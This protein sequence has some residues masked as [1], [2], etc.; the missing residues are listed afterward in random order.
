MEEKI[1]LNYYYG[2]EP[3]RLC[4]YRIPKILF[5]KAYFAGLSTDAKV[6]YGLMHDLMSMSIENRWLDSSNRVYIYFSV[7]RACAYLGCGKDKALKLFAELDT[8]TGIGLIER[9]KR[10][11][12]KAD[13]IY[14]K[15]FELPSDAEDKE[16]IKKLKKNNEAN[17]SYNIVVEKTDR[18]DNTTAIFEKKVVGKTEWSENPTPCGRENRLLEVGKS[19]SNKNNINNN[20]Y[21]Y[22]HVP[23]CLTPEED[24]CKE[25]Y[26]YEP[27]YDRTGHGSSE[28]IVLTMSK[29]IRKTYIIQ[30][31]N[32]THKQTKVNQDRQDLKS[33]YIAFLRKQ[34]DYDGLLS[35]DQ[36]KYEKTTIDGIINMVSDI[37][38]T[39]PPDGKEWINSRPYE[40]EAVKSHLLK[41][42][43]EAVMHILYSYG[44][45]C[46][47]VRNH[48]AYM[49]TTIYN[50]IDENDF[51]LTARVN[52]DMLGNKALPDHK[53]ETFG[54]V[55]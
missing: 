10:G 5:T 24:D 55:V 33:K 20:E 9:V 23:S 40:H 35:E 51:A 27:E 30:D 32:D 7:Q 17:A 48:R 47:N 11:Q 46:S 36:Y 25:S 19:D 38:V 53:R 12:G 29:P 1:T 21:N 49:L 37:A 2:D 42:S 28:P 54:G 15:S 39:T 34:I 16:E 14:V 18:S 26:D 45:N 13:I 3:D 50:A 52:Y 22:I 6:L 43:R 8:T 44:H 4:F 31:T 41:L